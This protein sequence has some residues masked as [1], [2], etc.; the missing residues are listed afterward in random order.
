MIMIISGPV[1]YAIVAAFFCGLYVGD[2]SGGLRWSDVVAALI[3]PLV[4]IGWFGVALADKLPWHPGEY[5]IDSEG[6]W[7]KGVRFTVLV[8]TSNAR[9][10]LA[11]APKPSS[12]T[13]DTE[14]QP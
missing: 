14:E 12:D 13:A 10:Y 8:S 4:V 3:W 1:G 5:V 9:L 11:R 2:R 7:K 6:A